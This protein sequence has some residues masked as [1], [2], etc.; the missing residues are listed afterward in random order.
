MGTTPAMRPPESADAVPPESQAA[1][2]PEPG[3]TRRAPRLNRYSVPVVGLDPAHEGLRIAHLTDLHVGMLT[4]SRFIRAAVEQARSA[5]PD[6]IVLTGDYVCYSPKHVAAL[7]EV[8]AG[9]DVPT[10]CVLGNHDYW[11]DAH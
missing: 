8:V 10:V 3:R 4:P 9:F 2:S 1:A 5:K 11:T 6:L 7:G